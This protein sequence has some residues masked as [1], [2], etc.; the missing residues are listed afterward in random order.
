MLRYE[1]VHMTYVS[2]E[3]TKEDDISWCDWSEQKRLPKPH[4]R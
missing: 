3:F 2:V 1:S 4:K